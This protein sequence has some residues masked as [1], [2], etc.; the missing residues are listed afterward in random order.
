[1]LGVERSTPSWSARM[2]SR[3]SSD[4]GSPPG[5]VEGPAGARAR[6]A[7]RPARRLAGT[8]SAMNVK[9]RLWQPV[10]VHLGRVPRQQGVDEERDDRGVLAVGSL[11]GPVHVEVA[12][13]HRLEPVQLP[14]H[15]GVVLAGQLGHRVGRARHQR[16]RLGRRHL[17]RAPP[18]TDDDD[19]STTRRTPA[20]SGGLQDG[21]RAVDVGVVGGERR[22]RPTAATD[23]ERGLVEHDLA[24]RD[25]LGHR[26]LVGHVALDEL[27]AVGDVL[28]PAG[29]Q[30]VEHDDLVAAAS[31]ASTRCEPMKPAPPVTSARIRPAPPAAPRRPAARRRRGRR[32][33]RAPRRW[34]RRPQ[35]A[36]RATAAG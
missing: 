21:Q 13:A 18:Y 36:C 28:E 26:R 32:G 11:P 29:G 24:A 14:E 22:A 3:S 17:R 30:V 16:R 10:A 8:T 2:P 9:S 5:D 7:P 25:G 19:A 4:D 35:R 1:M 31:R 34:R 33:G 6:P 15:P 12:Q 20:S 23:A 27:G